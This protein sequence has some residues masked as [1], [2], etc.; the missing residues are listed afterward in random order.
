MSAR[1]LSPTD[2]FLAAAVANLRSL[3]ADLARTEDSGLSDEERDFIPE[4]NARSST[5]P[6]VAEIDCD[7]TFAGKSLPVTLAVYGRYTPARKG[8]HEPG[9]RPYEPDDEAGFVPHAV[10]IGETDIL[11]DIGQKGEDA[12]VAYV[13]ENC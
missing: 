1:P 13:M 11:G 8:G 2:S 10:K 6:L 5:A 3:N 4:A 9:E 12:I 7:L